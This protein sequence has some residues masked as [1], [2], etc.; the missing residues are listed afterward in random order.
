MKKLLILTTALLMFITTSHGAT[1]YPEV[2]YP[3]TFYRHNVT[4][5][6][7]TRISRYYPNHGITYDGRYLANNIHTAAH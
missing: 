3:H 7:E 5:N 2:F 6:E 4:N 1:F